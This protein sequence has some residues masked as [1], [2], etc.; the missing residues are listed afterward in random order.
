MQVTG[1]FH[2]AIK[3]NDLDATVK[4]YTDVLGMKLAPRP[5]FG[6]PGAWIAAGDDIPIIHIYAGGSALVDGKAP[7]YGTGSVDHVSLTIKGWDEC[8]ERVKRLGYDWRAAIVPGT[9]LWQI[10]VHDPSGVMME[11]T[12]DGKAEGRPTPEIPAD[13]MYQPGKPFGTPK[14]KAA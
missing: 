7:P 6:F 13:R 14:Q 5:D 4:F 3:T 1:L 2:V 9:S 11:L 8:L 10:F 12:F